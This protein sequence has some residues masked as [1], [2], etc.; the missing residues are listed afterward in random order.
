MT[1]TATGTARAIGMR[2]AT[3]RTDPED[4]GAANS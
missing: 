2:K 1:A 4:L 3:R